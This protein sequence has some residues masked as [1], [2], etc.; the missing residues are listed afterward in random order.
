MLELFLLAQQPE[1]PCIDIQEVIEVVRDAK[2]V[3]KKE[4]RR[5]IHRIEI[6]SS[7]KNS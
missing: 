2:N 5:I 6:N 7:C 4:K 3:S 1:V